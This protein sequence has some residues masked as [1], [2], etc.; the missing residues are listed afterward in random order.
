MGGGQLGDN[1][2]QSGPLQGGQRQGTFVANN[3][4]STHAYVP[5]NQPNMT[6]IPSTP[7]AYMPKKPHMAGTPHYGN[8]PG[9]GQT[10]SPFA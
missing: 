9:C 8:S 4:N 10:Q 7:H 1:T 6:G 2:H 5:H 3:N